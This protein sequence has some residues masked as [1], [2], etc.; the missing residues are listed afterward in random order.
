MICPPRSLHLPTHTFTI[1][2][3]IVNE[4][5]NMSGVSESNVCS[6]GADLRSSCMIASILARIRLQSPELDG[7]IFN[8]FYSHLRAAQ[9][10][11]ELTIVFTH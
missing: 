8:L 6:R 1:D 2:R 10:H 11:S 9:N 3:L 4:L 5:R 7:T